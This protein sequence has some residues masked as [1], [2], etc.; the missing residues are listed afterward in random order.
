MRHPDADDV[1]IAIV[2]ACIET[3]EN[4][5]LIAES[6]P[7]RARH[8]AMHAL[9][10]IFPTYDRVKLAALVGSPIKPQHFWRNSCNQVANPTGHSSYAVAWWSGDA[11]DRVIRAIEADRTRRAIAPL[12]TEELADLPKELIAEL[13]PEARAAA[14]KVQ[15]EAPEPVVEAE[16]VQVAEPFKVGD[17]VEHPT[18]KV[19]KVVKVYPWNP[20]R[21]DFPLL[22][23]FGGRTQMMYA[24]VVTTAAAQAAVNERSPLEQEWLRRAD[25]NYAIHG[26]KAEPPPY[27]PP[28]LPTRAKTFRQ[29][30]GRLEGNGY[31]PPTGTIAKAILD[32]VED[33]RPVFDRGGQFSERRPNQQP[34]LSKR[35]LEEEL[36]RAVANTKPRA[37]E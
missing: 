37:D 33:D 26:P 36:R 13:S 14:E 35:Q 17:H 18:Y 29:G 31:R 34:V 15:V 32:E 30:P 4:P 24:K 27:R 25:A 19:G 12:R 1:A 5:L 20:R 8:Y 16:K 9:A 11:Y 10:H 28:P 2:A 7:L 3:S 22:I 23:D 21:K 6:R